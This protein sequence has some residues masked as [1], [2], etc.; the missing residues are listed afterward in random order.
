[1]LGEEHPGTLIAMGNL[2]LSYSALGRSKEAAELETVV[3]EKRKLLLGEEHPET[4]IAMGNLT[5]SYSTLGRSNEA[6]DLRA[7]LPQS[8]PQKR[9]ECEY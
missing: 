1:L 9:E 5:A 7:L 2:A 4:L 6:A 3:L 8:N